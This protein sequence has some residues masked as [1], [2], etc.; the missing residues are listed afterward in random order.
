[1]GHPVRVLFL[2]THNSARSQMAEGLLRHQSHGQVET[3]SAG[4]HPTQLHSTAVRVMADIGI[5][6]S[7]QRA[8]HLNEVEEQLFD[9]VITVCDTVYEVCPEFPG[10]PYYLHW[11]LPDP[12]AY[13]GPEAMQQQVFRQTRIQLGQLIQGLLRL[14]EGT[15]SERDIQL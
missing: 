4:T 1:M 6:I 13:E 2:C 8:K 12:A 5:D 10:H 3:G 14:I 15:Q 11:G 9:Y 7:R